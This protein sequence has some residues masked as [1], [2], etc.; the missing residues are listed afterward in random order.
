MNEDR[1]KE[2]NVCPGCGRHCDLSMPGCERGET[3]ARTGQLPERKGPEGRR[4][5]PEVPG[6]F[7]HHG[8]ASGEPGAGGPHGRGPG[9]EG[10]GPRPHEHRGE[11]PRGPRPPHPPRNV[12]ESPRYQAE[13]VNGKLLTLLRVMGQTGHHMDARG[14]QGRVLDRKSVV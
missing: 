7:R 6:Q 3:F 10:H 1:K 2:M 8:P 5:A 4:L 12:T 14:G 9:K 13:D 11:G